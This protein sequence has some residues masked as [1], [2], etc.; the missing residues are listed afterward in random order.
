MRIGWLM[1]ARS[2]SDA[3][4]LAPWMLSRQN[5]TYG[6]FKVFVYYPQTQG[7]EGAP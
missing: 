1:G 5:I 6:V 3:Q 2:L 7:Y 4:D